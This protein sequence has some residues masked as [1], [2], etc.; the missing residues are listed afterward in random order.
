[1]LRL[2]KPVAQKPLGIEEGV[3]YPATTDPVQSWPPLSH[4]HWILSFLRNGTKA[5]ERHPCE[6]EKRGQKVRMEVYIPSLELNDYDDGSNCAYDN[7][8]RPEEFVHSNPD[9]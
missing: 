2:E 3:A 1:M 9:I 8:E 6:F 7:Y 5:Y 4:S